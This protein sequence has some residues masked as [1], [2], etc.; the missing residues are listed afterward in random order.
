MLT[1]S[2]LDITTLKLTKSDIRLSRLLKIDFYDY[3]IHDFLDPIFLSRG[4]RE[5]FSDGSQLRLLAERVPSCENAYNSQ[6]M[7]R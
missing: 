6:V 5:N 7:K 1:R 3:R 4:A 2:R